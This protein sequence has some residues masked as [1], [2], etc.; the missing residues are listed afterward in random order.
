MTRSAS[1]LIASIS[2]LWTTDCT[3]DYGDIVPHYCHVGMD[4]GPIP[5]RPAKATELLQVQV[6]I[7]HG[8]RTQSDSTFC[9]EGD[10]EGNY[11]CGLY[12]L[13]NSIRSGGPMTWPFRTEYM[14]GRNGL[15]G[16]CLTGQLV[17]EGF[18]MER[19]NGRRLREAY[20]DRE[21]FLPVTLPFASHADLDSTLFFR[22]T[23]VPRTKQ[24]AMAL[25][26]GLYEEATNPSYLSLRTMDIDQ[27]N[28]LVTKKVCPAVTWQTGAF[29]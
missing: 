2:F 26:S 29:F 8:A 17:E 1:I 10:N 25:I 6:F 3:Y 18:E 23:D 28:M 20:V 24:S 22:S 12:Y 4:W 16:N 19:S 13:E 7:R 21:R 5:A 9:W 27:E 14:Q 15:P 11:T